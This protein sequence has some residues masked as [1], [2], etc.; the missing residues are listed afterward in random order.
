M[1]LLI[2]FP[3]EFRVERFTPPYLQGAN[4]ALRPTA[5]VLSSKSLTANSATFTIRFNVPL[6]TAGVKV[7][8]YYGGFVTHSVHM[9]HRMLFLDNTGFRAGTVA[10]TLVVTMPPNRNTC[11]PGPYVVY[12]VA[13][14]IPSVGQFVSVS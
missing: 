1:S 5:M 8:L 11:P 14:G 4:Q 10:Q 2:W 6:T 12:V 7:A 3:P 9:G 13:D